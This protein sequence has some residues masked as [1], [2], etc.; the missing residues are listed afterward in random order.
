MKITNP[1]LVVDVSLWDHHI[2]TDELLAGGVVSVICGLYRYW[3]GS[4]YVL[5][6]NCVRIC[7]AV[8]ASKLSLQ[9]YYYYYPQR[10]PKVEANWFVD[11]MFEYRYPVCFAWT[12]AEDHGY[13]MDVNVRS[14]KFRM[15]TDHVYSRF[16]K[17]GVYTNKN[18]IVSYA[19]QMDLWLPKYP[20]WIPQYGYQPTSKIMAEWSEISQKWLPT[21]DIIQARGQINPVGHQFT[22]DRFMLPGVYNQYAGVPFWPNK[23]RLPVDISVFNDEWLDSFEGNIVPPPVPPVINYID[24]KVVPN[25]INVRKGPNSWFAWVRYAYHD[26][27]LHITGTAQSPQ[28]PVNG[29]LQMTD[30]NWVYSAYLVKV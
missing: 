18:F 26:E 5:H 6:P 7:D 12:D 17:V 11:T 16:P 20:A 14:E 4:K 24:Y 13:D 27:V 1:R 23:G 19:P 29:Y 15:F 8:K 22:G 2:N 28:T 21:Y 25:A 10:D 3:D 30:G 9:T